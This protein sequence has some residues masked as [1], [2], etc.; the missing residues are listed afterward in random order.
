[1]ENSSTQASIRLVTSGPPV[2]T[3]GAARILLQMLEQAAEL[4]A[5]PE[6]RFPK[7]S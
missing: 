1:M 3:V 5:R 6:G 7:A 4:E 2:L